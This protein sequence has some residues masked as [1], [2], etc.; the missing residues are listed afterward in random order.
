MPQ[1]K[2]SISRCVLSLLTHDKREREA[3][4][5]GKERDDEAD[6]K[7]GDLKT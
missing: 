5:L 3:E 6:E 2:S 7:R 4:K 1:Q